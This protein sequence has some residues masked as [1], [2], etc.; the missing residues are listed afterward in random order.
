MTEKNL[1]KQ[2]IK[3]FLFSSFIF[4]SKD[5]LKI[6]ILIFMIIIATG[7]E[8]FVLVFLSP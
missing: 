6:L 1:F 8:L 7:V 4:R 2:I 3:E 5:K